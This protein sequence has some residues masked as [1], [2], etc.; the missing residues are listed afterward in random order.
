[1][2]A[3]AAAE[4]LSGDIGQESAARAATASAKAM[5]DSDSGC[6]NTRITKQKTKGFK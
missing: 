3:A 6:R 5:A 1:M 2:A 4:L